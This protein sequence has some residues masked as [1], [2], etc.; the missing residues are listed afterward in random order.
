MTVDELKSFFRTYNDQH[1]FTLGESDEIECKQSIRIDAKGCPRSFDDSIRA[2]AALANNKGG[3]LLYGIVESKNTNG[4]KT[5]IAEGLSDQKF[6]TLDPGN[7]SMILG[8]S[9]MPFVNV[10]AFYFTLAE[11]FFAGFTVEMAENRPV[12]SIKNTQKTK[13]GCI[14]FRYPG[15]SKPIKYSELD[16]IFKSRETRQLNR[17]SEIFST[18]VAL[19][20]DESL[21]DIDQYLTELPIIK[22]QKNSGQ[23]TI[24][25]GDGDKKITEATYVVEEGVA[26]SDEDIIHNFIYQRQVRHPMSYVSHY[27]QIARVYLPIYYYLNLANFKTPETRVKAIEGLKIRMTGHVKKVLER[28]K[29]SKGLA[30]NSSAAGKVYLD[31]LESGQPIDFFDAELDAIKAMRALSRINK[32]S[33]DR[34]IIFASL[35]SGWKYHKAN[36]DKRFFDALCYA[37]CHLDYLY[38]E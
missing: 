33:A 10:N 7:V 31:I 28:V 20:D 36:L 1:L 15:Q 18:I 4:D 25:I 12:L 29:V 13:E 16:S 14:Y 38:F 11:R 5:W 17:L 37:T 32:T 34:K 21:T 24:T 2:I 30:N 22:A 35:E 23:R 19:S 9:L 6:K 8:E 3:I 26:V 27:C